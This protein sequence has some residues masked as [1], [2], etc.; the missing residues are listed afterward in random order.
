MNKMHLSHIKLHICNNYDIL[1]KILTFWT[2]AAAELVA[3]KRA[4]CPYLLTYK[5]QS[6]HSTPP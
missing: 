5:Q 4:S 6:V 1:I 3:V 2:E